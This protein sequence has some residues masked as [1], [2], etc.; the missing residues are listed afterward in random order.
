MR[1]VA[2]LTSALLDWTKSVCPEVVV[3]AA[4]GKSRS[5]APQKGE[6]RI[7]VRLAAVE[8]LNGSRSRD[9]IAS[10]L[11]LDYRFELE[12]A[13]AADEHQALA[14][15]A[16]AMLGR[17]DL[18]DGESPVRGEAASLAA[19]FVVERR[20]GLPRPKPV[21]E[22][23]FVLSPTA[24]IAGHVQAGNG[25]RIPRAQLVIGNSER[26]IVADNDGQFGFA[27][28][29]DLPVRATVTAKGRTAD[30]ELTPGADNVITLAMEP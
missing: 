1:D 16:F 13:D 26:L 30:V 24:R 20:R 19:S 25:A 9:A 27:A 10:R 7:L 22:T 14:D 17:D 3:V 23:V 29:S 21:R 28:P 6:N 11:K 4:S 18:A 5:E 15:L 2:D 12:F 8:G